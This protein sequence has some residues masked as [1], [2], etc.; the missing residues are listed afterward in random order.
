[1]ARNWST[2]EV[3][4][5]VQDYLDMLRFQLAGETFNKSERNRRL[6]HSSEYQL[7]RLFEFRNQPKLFTLAGDIAGHVGLQAINYRAHF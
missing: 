3:E 7:Y 5:A 2:A 4:A 1:M 6:R